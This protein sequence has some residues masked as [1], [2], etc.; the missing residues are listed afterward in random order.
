MIK[1]PHLFVLQYLNNRFQQL[2]ATPQE[3]ECLL[4]GYL[5]PVIADTY[6]ESYVAGAIQWIQ[7]NE[8]NF[9]LASRLDMDKLP[10]V[11]VS[12]EG[13]IES[14]TFIGEQGG[15]STYEIEPTKYADFSVK[16]VQ[17]GN[18]I[19]SKESGL[20]EKIWRGLVIQ[21]ASGFQANLVDISCSG[22]DAS[23]IL[24]KPATL[25]EVSLQ[26]WSAVSFVN[27]RVRSFGSSLDDVRIRVFVSVPGEPELCEMVSTVIRYLLK[28][29]RLFLESHG[30]YEVVTTHGALSISQDFPETQVYV[31]EF[32][33][34][35][36]LQ[37]QWVLSDFK[38]PD[39][40][41]IEKLSIEQRNS[42]K[43]S[44]VWHRKLK[45]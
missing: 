30:L 42:Q 21:H 26:D 6:G 8:I 17:D 29:A 45:K 34:E 5:D 28:Q 37:D 27:S 9:I 15:T 38:N 14:Q 32:S 36:K 4:S 10:S 18:L 41:V 25:S 22:D 31:M 3:L 44:V 16:D 19:I 43:A 7:E 24:S 12:Y 1:L 39:N 23:L 35:G 33:L 40:F 11:A 2:R 13:G 20:M